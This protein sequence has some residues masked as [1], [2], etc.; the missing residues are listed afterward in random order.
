MTIEII[1][2]AESVE[3]AKSLVLNNVDILYIGEETFGLRLPTSFSYDELKEITQFAH[4]HGKKVR[5]ALNAMMHNEHIKDLLPYLNFLVDIQVD[6]VTVGDPGVIHLMKKNDMPIPFV[7]DA[8]TLVTS[9]N[10]INFWAK[11]GAISAV[12]ARELT[13]PELV[14]I[15]K[16]AKVPVEILVYGATCIH[17]S[18]R[19]LVKNYFNFVDMNEETDKERNLFISEPK[20]KDTHYSIYEDRNGTHIFANNDVDLFTELSELKDVG[21]T[22]WKLDGIFTQG[23][24]FLTIAK[25]FVKAKET[26]LA[27][28]WSTSLQEE[29]H[30]E[31]ISLHPPERGLDKGFYVKNPED[32]R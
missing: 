18:K 6:E 5:V 32:I 24:S 9:A 3:Q 15:S 30:N 17:Q 8:Q 2:T 26:I 12:L 13:Y 25:L 10:Q 23:D 1:A 31:L 20:N 7:H 29:L 28:E 27:N 19:Q 14:E 4:E 16:N 22:Q 21:I 11:R